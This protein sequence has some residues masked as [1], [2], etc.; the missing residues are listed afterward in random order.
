MAHHGS[1][2]L[3]L[4]HVGRT[5]DPLA[6]GAAV[7]GKH[8][9]DVPHALDETELSQLLVVL[10]EKLLRIVGGPTAVLPVALTDDVHAHTRS[11]HCCSLFELSQNK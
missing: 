5:Q 6:D 3:H 4:A 11:R 9:V 2:P 10:V 1:Q 8:V 7:R